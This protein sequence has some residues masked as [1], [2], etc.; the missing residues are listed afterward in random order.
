MG[1]YNE[2]DQWEPSCEMDCELC[3]C[4]GDCADCDGYGYEYGTEGEEDQ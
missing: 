1:T 4:H 2:E 3:G